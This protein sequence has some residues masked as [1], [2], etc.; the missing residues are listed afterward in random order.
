MRIIAAVVLLV[1]DSDKLT[2]GQN[3]TITDQQAEKRLLRSNPPPT[4][5]IG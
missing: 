1:R 3:L 5:T 2:L 4:P